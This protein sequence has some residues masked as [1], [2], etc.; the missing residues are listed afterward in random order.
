MAGQKRSRLEQ[1]DQE[2]SD[3]S[4]SIVQAE[5][6]DIDISSALAGKRARR[7]SSDE[8]HVTDDDELQEFINDSIAKRN[9]K[10]GTA[11]LKKTKSKGK[12]KGEVGGGSFQSMGLHPFLLRALTIQGYRTPTP[13]QRATIPS[14]LASPPRDLVGMARTGSGKTLAYMIPLLQRLGGRHSHAFGVRAIILVPARELA[15]QVLKV[16]KGL[17]K[18]W[19]DD[20]GHHAGDGVDNEDVIKLGQSETLRWGLVVGGESMNEQFEMI[21]SNPDVIIATPGRL[22]HLIVEMNL[23][24]AKAEYVVFDEADRLFELGFSTALTEILARLPASR[25]T[26][27]FSATLPKSLVEFAK[28]GLR[29]PKLVR[30]DAESKIS[31]DLR[32]AFF[33]VKP[34]EKDACLLSLLRDVIKVPLGDSYGISDDNQNKDTKGKGKAK[35]GHP[36]QTAPHQTLVFAATKH[37]VE[38]LSTLLTAAGYAVSSLYGSLVQSSRTYQM[39]QFLARKT[40]ILVVTDVAARGLDIPIL[41]HVVNYD[42]PVG[43]RIFVHRVGR[44]ARAGRRGWAWSFVTHSEAAYLSDL[45]LFLGRPLLSANSYPPAVRTSEVPYTQ[46]L[47]LGPFPRD[48]IDVEVEYIRSLEI[49]Q[50]NLTSLRGV[51]ERGQSM[52]ERSRGKASVASYKRAKELTKSGGGWA[53]NANGT[54][55][56]LALMQYTLEGNADNGLEEERSREE[57][58]LSMVRAV[59]SFMPTETVFE[60]G[61]RGKANAE[62]A[63]L[64]RERRRALAKTAER[65]RLSTAAAEESV[66]NDDDYTMD[67]DNV[68]IEMADEEDVAAVFGVSS[69]KGRTSFRDDGFYMS[70]YQKDSHTEKGYSLADGASSFAVQANSALLDLAGDVTVTERQRHKLTW[71]KKKKNFVKGDGVGADNIKLVRTENGT[72]LPATYRSGRFEEW[73]KKAKVML[74]KVGEQE[75]RKKDG[76]GGLGGK[77]WKHSRVIEAKPLDKLHKDYER[78]ARQLKKK[79]VEEVGTVEGNVRGPD[80]TLSDKRTKKLGRRQGGKSIGR[81]KNELKTVEQIHKSRKMTEK[82]RAKNARPSRKGKR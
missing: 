38:Y 16:G 12:G 49:T 41:E 34:A 32:M 54:H 5:G 70:H 29:N 64:M 11:L 19:R 50:N 37:H 59:N 25:Q 27:L 28:A 8:D 13:I 45:Q 53:S 23:S 17:V 71:D 76:F 67:N 30:L 14:L 7:E 62:T 60:V 46:S 33:S 55:P 81:L 44:T 22:L 79:K 58:R 1:D 20:G 63:A 52:Y 35:P 24:L 39:S 3:S 21:S 31:T 69:Q 68:E 73:Q 10:G 43:A 51:M 36:M 40:Q 2:N 65:T 47:I 57:K 66:V 6:D 80:R 56:V 75:L 9:V 82:K 72:R 61:T 26:L 4:F 77:K 78:K 48:T 74:P 15:L 42:F 18:G